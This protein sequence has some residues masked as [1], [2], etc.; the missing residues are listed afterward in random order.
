M[1]ES[2]WKKL[3]LIWE[4]DGIKLVRNFSARLLTVIVRLELNAVA[5]GLI[6][7]T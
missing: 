7:P 3:W 4:E 6:F 2:L 5:I 1:P